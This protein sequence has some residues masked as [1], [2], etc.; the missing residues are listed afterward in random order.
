MPRFPQ[1]LNA[2]W[3]RLAIWCC[4]PLWIS[5]SRPSIHYKCNSLSNQSQ[6]I[7]TRFYPFLLGKGPFH[8]QFAPKSTLFPPFFSYL[9]PHSSNCRL[10][11][12]RSDVISISKWPLFFG[13][14]T[15]ELGALCFKRSNRE[16]FLAPL[17]LIGLTDNRFVFRSVDDDKSTPKAWQLKPSSPQTGA[18]VAIWRRQ[19]WEDVMMSNCF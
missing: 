8:Q 14:T 5:S 1:W 11:L 16:D 4:P 10:V 18:I 17:F 9:A 2:F 3:I 7:L 13:V 19:V 6:P 15:F 12:V